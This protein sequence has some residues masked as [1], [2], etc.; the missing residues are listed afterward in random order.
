M[1][2]K[3]ILSSCDFINKNSKNTI[4]NNID[5]RVY[6]NNGIDL[7]LEYLEIAVCAQHCN[8]GVAVDCNWQSDISGLYAAGEA[9]GTFGV[10]R[11][12]G[13]ALNAGQV[14]SYRAAQYIS[15]QNK[16]FICQEEFS[17]MI[18]PR[19]LYHYLA[20]DRFFHYNS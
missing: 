3:M 2:M 1:I 7:S 6:K 20:S 15:S 5:V 12:G 17:N 8:G 9:A 16:N 11:P 18:A 10:Y 19:Y 4:L 14:G 13:S